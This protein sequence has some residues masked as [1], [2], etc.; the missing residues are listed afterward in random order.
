M[1]FRHLKKKTPFVYGNNNALLEISSAH[2]FGACTNVSCFEMIYM[3]LFFPLY[4]CAHKAYI[5]E[6]KIHLFDV[7]E[8]KRILPRSTRQYQETKVVVAHDSQR[9]HG[10]DTARYVNTVMNM[11]CSSEYMVELS[12][13]SQICRLWK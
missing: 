5:D 8:N 1:V 12:L 6:P 9:F 10:S 11:V 7:D 2:N 13:V 3:F 4:C